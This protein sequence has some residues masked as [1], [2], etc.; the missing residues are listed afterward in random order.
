MAGDL[1]DDWFQPDDIVGI[2]AGTSTPDAVIEGVHR[3]LDRL[4]TEKHER[5]MV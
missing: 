2:T 3:R 5:Q 4:G 1:R